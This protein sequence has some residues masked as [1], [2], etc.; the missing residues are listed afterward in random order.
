MADGTNVP[1]PPLRLRVYQQLRQAIEQ[2]TL[3][4]GTR[5]PPS[6]EHARALGVARNTVLWALERLRAEGYVQARVGDGSYVAPSLAAL[7]SAAPARSLDET[8]LSKRGRAIADTALRWRPPL[9]AAAPFRIGAPEVAAFPHAVWDRLARQLTPAERLLTSQYLDPAGLPALR[10]AIAQ[11]LLFSRGLRCDGHQVLVCSGSQQAID[12]I[13]RLL[14]D[15]GDEVLVEDP[16]YPG[17]RACLIGH[18]AQARPVAVDDEGLDI[19]AGARDWPAA[20]MAVVTPTHQFP[21]GVRMSLE[22]R[23]ALLDWAR[24]RDAWIVED[25]YDGEFQ[26]G[27]HRIPPLAGLARA[28]RVL[29]V[30]TFSKSLHPGLR[31]GFIVLPPGLANAFASAKALC[32]RH[33]PGELQWQLARFI[34]DGHLLRHLRRMRELYPQRQALLIDALA[35]ATRGAVKL[36]ASEQGM[37]IAHEVSGRRNDAALSGKAREAGVLLAPL[38][39][40][41][42]QSPRRGWLFGYAGYDAAALREAARRVGPLFAS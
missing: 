3:S 9:V 5:L 14:L 24:A 27:A 30:G 18:G 34:T 13:G 42:I 31:L 32:D 25:D 17:I 33:S 16:G 40:Y 15:E 37:H 8:A 12:L 38:S 1:A 26:Y 36:E 21:L 23:I 29:Y 4:A 20:R 28:E 6:R 41:A 10:E 2:G 39:A 11:W 7:R 19:A 22:R 35:K